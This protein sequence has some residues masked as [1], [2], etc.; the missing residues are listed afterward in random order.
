MFRLLTLPLLLLIVFQNSAHANPIAQ[1]LRAGGRSIVAKGGQTAVRHSARHVA[2]NVAS[3]AAKGGASRLA[4]S[5]SAQA[6]RHF[7]NKVVHSGGK[8]VTKAPAYAD[9]L[10]KVSSKLS[11]RNH[12]RL[13]MLAPELKKSGQAGNVVRHLAHN[14]KADDAMEFLWRHR[15][16]L[17]AATAAT[18]VA[19]HGDEIAKASG[20]FIAKPLIENSVEHVVKP[21]SSL[22]GRIIGIAAAVGGALLMFAWMAQPGRF[23]NLIRFRKS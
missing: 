1:L 16:K 12:R 7:G 6:M 22:L 19:I 17:A 4:L 9:D 11:A 8:A 21:V 20:E 10:A 5:R 15:G 2:T 18:T 13:M 14:D 23:A 3:T